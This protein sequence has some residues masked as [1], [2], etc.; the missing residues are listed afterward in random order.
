MKKYNTFKEI[1]LKNISLEEFKRKINADYT[2]QTE[3]GNQEFDWQDF[4][5]TNFQYLNSKKEIKEKEVICVKA[6]LA[7]K[8]ENIVEHKLI[9]S[10][11][12]E[13]ENN[14][15]LIIKGSPD[16]QT[17]IKSKLLGKKT[18]LTNIKELWKN[19]EIKYPEPILTVNFLLWLVDKYNKEEVLHVNNLKYKILDITFISDNGI[20]LSGIKKKG[21]GNNLINDPIIKATL[22]TVDTID[23]LGIKL[24]FE[25]GVVNFILHNNGEFDL[26]DE[27]EIK[28]PIFISPAQEYGI[29]KI[30]FFIREILI[31]GLREAFNNEGGENLEYFKKI[32]SEFLLN[33]IKEFGEILNINIK[34]EVSSNE[35]IKKI[36]L[37]S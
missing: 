5:K 30:G 29:E 32:K 24:H 22:A 9:N 15:H 31:K 21:V 14:L 37:K 2:I 11:I 6:K 4:S 8:N 34:N 20:Y 12:I 27:C 7:S 25:T 35:N 13:N 17:K 10:F 16:I 3:F 18:P 19:I 36:I 26:S 28:L 1:I 23:A 33:T